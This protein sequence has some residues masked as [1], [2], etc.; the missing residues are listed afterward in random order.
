M[1]AAVAASLFVVTL[2]V[3]TVDSIVLPVCEPL[4]AQQQCCAVSSLAGNA[5]LHIPP[6]P[7]IR[8]WLGVEVGPCQSSRAWKCWRASAARSFKSGID[9]LQNLS[10]AL[11]NIAALH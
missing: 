6:F 1:H 7:H 8:R 3:L 11:S 10:L 4:E 2:V 5:F 9:D